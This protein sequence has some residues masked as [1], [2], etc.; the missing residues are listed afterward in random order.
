VIDAKIIRQLRTLDWDFPESIQGTSANIHWYPG[1]FPVQLP[2]SLIQALSSRD[3]LIFDP[4]GGIGFSATEALRIG[5]RAWIVENNPIAFLTSYATCG[6]ILLSSIDRSLTDYT[7]NYLNDAVMMNRDISHSHTLFSTRKMINIDRILSRLMSPSPKLVCNSFFIKS[8]NWNELSHWYGDFTLSAIKKLWNYVN[9]SVDSYFLR[10]I[11]FVMLSDSLKVCSS[12]TRSWGHIADN[13]LPKTFIEKNLFSFLF[14]WVSKTSKMLFN[15]NIDTIAQLDNTDRRFWAT[16][17]DWTSGAILSNIPPTKANLLLTSPPYGGAIDYI[18][19]QRLSL[20]LLGYDQH[21]IN[22]LSSKEI[23][24]RCK[25][26]SSNSRSDWALDLSRSIEI[27]LNYLSDTSIIVII[28]P[29]KDSG[30]DVGNNLLIDT[31]LNCGW[32]VTFRTD[33]SI[34]KLR[35]RQSWSSIK[36]E[37]IYVFTKE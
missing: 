37:T 4:F 14:R 23:G 24:A 15:A 2:F 29:H 6:L 11:S 21:D 31:L 33:R 10:I 12:Q 27:Q 25:R 7:L 5:R 13:C 36:K 3:K 20:Y 32:S 1:T 8:S 35:T 16:Y 17:H 18:K 30:R 22:S 34:R 28:L 9:N 19:A 26:F